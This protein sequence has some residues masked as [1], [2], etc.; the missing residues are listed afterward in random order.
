M[1]SSVAPNLLARFIDRTPWAGIPLLAFKPLS[2][3]HPSH[4][5]RV[6]CIPSASSLCAPRL[7]AGT[8]VFAH[9]PPVP[10]PT[11][12]KDR[13]RVENS[14]G[15]KASLQGRYASA[16]FDLASENGTVSDRKSTRLNPSH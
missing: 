3:N 5:L 11:R 13:T 2:A 12:C 14:G 16:L 4:D 9:A 7:R 1:S 10:Q 6:A 15:I 8:C